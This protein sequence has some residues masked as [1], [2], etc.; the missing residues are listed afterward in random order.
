MSA[1]RP[2]T[3]ARPRSVQPGSGSDV[4]RPVLAASSGAP[5]L[6][7]VLLIIGVLTAGLVG[8]LLLNTATA[9]GSFREHDL[10]QQGSDLSVRA[11]SLQRDVGALDTSEALAAA[12][13]RL[14]MVPGGPPV[15]LVIRSDGRSTVIGTP[16]GATAPPPPQ[17]PP[18]TAHPTTAQ[19]RA[20]APRTTA[21]APAR[22]GHR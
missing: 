5:R 19:P 12:A 17:P 21:H 14:G 13:R 8:L 11:Q 20:T 9:S 10:Q 4:R 2:R 22:G 1:E 7:F 6:P 16:I 15:F 3:R 18:P